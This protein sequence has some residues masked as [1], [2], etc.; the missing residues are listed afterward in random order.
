MEAKTRLILLK[1][2]HTAIWSFY[3]V[4]IVYTVFAAIIG[5][6]DFYFLTAVC[7]VVLEGIILLINGWQCPLTRI[8]EKYS[9]E[10][11]LG[12]D[13]YIPKW[14][15]KHNKTIFTTLFSA[16]IIIATYRILT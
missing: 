16:G 10:V 3:V 1:L 6:L 9:D 4:I 14:L 13:L 2:L 15:A 7:L 5:R 11:S 8:A 12:F